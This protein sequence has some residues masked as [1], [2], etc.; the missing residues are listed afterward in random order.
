MF[1]ILSLEKTT[2]LHLKNRASNAGPPMRW[3]S[4]SFRRDVT[5]GAAMHHQNAFLMGAY[6]VI[7]WLPSSGY[8]IW[9]I[10]GNGYYM[11][12]DC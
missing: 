3:A 5:W 6:T 4:G 1:P 8:S 9:L 10:Y 12:N 11:V 2:E 7:I